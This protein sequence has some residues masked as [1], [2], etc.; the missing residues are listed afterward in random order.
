[1]TDRTA[2]DGPI[3][4]PCS[5]LY[6]SSL[7]CVWCLV[8]AGWQAA[9]STLPRASISPVSEVAGHAGHWCFDPPPLT[10]TLLGL[11]GDSTTTQ[12]TFRQPGRKPR[13]PLTWG[14]VALGNRVVIVVIVNG[15]WCAWRAW[16]GM[17]AW[18]GSQVGCHNTRHHAT[19]FSVFEGGRCIFHGLFFHNAYTIYTKRRIL[20][21]GRV[22][23]AYAV[24]VG[25]DEDARTKPAAH[26]CVSLPPLRTRLFC[27]EES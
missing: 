7:R 12:Q 5:L 25:W 18:N 4:F 20:M 15:S 10:R 21:N 27:C 9:T 16:L 3:L 8:L 14:A 1:M 23:V 19:T 24:N 2:A 17:L 22:A 11:L 6:L 26:D 13:K